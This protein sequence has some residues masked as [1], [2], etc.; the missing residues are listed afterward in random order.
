MRLI[1]NYFLVL[2]TIEAQTTF[3]SNYSGVLRTN[4]QIYTRYGQTTKSFYYQAIEVRVSITGSYTFTS[5]S[6]ISDTY[7]YLYQGN[8]YPT[9][10]Q[11][12]IVISDDNGAGGGQFQLTA[13]LRSDIRYILIFTTYS[14]LAIGTINFAGTGPSL[15]SILPLNINTL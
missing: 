13:S 5:S 15:I 2:T 14:P 12:N 4:N 6:T 9:Y 10:P 8:F 3:T 7:G 1:Y 11:Y